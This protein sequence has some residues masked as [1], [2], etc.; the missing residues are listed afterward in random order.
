MR[1]LLRLVRYACQSTPQVI[2]Q[3]AAERARDELVGDYEMLVKLD[4]MPLLLEVH[5]RREVDSR[6]AAVLREL[7]VLEYRNGER[8]AAVHPAA[9]ATRKFQRLY[10]EWRKENQRSSESAK[11]QI[12]EAAKR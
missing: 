12:S 9:R 4:D 10:K 1:D 3:T 6:Y 11:E 2:D 5:R 7:V 8:W